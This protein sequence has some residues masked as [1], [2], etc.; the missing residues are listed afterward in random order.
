MSK[1]KDELTDTPTME[2]PAPAPAPVSRRDPAAVTFQIARPCVVGDDTYG[3]GDEARLLAADIHPGKIKWFCLVG[4]IRG[5]VPGIVIDDEDRR[6][7]FAPPTVSG[8]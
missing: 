8:G 4:A 1:K 6:A 5:P 3:P 2:A 7:L